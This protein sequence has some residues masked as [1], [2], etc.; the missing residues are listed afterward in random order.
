[1]PVSCG[2]VSFRNLDRPPDGGTSNIYA[3][4]QISLGEAVLRSIS[5]SDG[6][7]DAVLP[8]CAIPGPVDRLRR[9][10]RP[11]LDTPSVR[12]SA[13]SSA[14]GGVRSRVLAAVTATFAG[15]RSWPRQVHF[16]VGRR[17]AEKKPGEQRGPSQALFRMLLSKRR[18]LLIIAPQRRIWRFKCSNSN[19]VPALIAPSLPP[20]SKSSDQ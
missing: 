20:S 10:P 12:E 1:M 17:W 6:G 11:R 2:T 19:L 5:H 4:D 3:C 13:R 14:L 8:H 18:A 16:S 9:R 7:C 15:F